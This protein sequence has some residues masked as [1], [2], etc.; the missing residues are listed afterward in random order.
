MITESLLRSAKIRVR[1]LSDNIL[2]EDIKQ[3]A[4]VALADLERIGVKKEILTDCTD[5]I[6]REA[7]LTFVD[8]NYGSNPDREKLMSSY[9]MFLTKIKGSGKYGT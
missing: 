4:E 5:P 1:K 9:N 2:D 7:V 6:I 3:L 8:A